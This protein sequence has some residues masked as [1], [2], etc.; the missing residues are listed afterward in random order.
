MA[1]EHRLDAIRS[2]VLQQARERRVARVDQKPEPV[3]L[4]EVASARLPSGGP[5]ATAAEN[6][7]TH[8]NDFTQLMLQAAM[9][10]I[11]HG[12]ALAASA[13]HGVAL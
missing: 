3:V 12:Q 11:S 5:G 2:E 6:S 8:G 7:E 13:G 9:L 10:R 4:D 1:D